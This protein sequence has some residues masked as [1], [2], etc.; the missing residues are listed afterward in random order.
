M[1]RSLAFWEGEGCIEE[2][3]AAIWAMSVPTYSYTTEAGIDKLYTQARKA[4]INTQKATVWALKIMH[5]SL[6]HE[7]APA[8]IRLVYVAEALQYAD[9][10]ET[11]AQYERMLRDNQP[12][13][14]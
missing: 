13:H 11:V 3:K 9:T 1:K 6:I 10:R 12:T 5:Y 14:W 2:R 8:T 7:G 4:G